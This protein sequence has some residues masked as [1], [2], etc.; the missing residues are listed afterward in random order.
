VAVTE[1]EIIAKMLQAAPEMIS[2]LL[3]IDSSPHQVEDAVKAIVDRILK[4]L[5]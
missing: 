4:Q 3:A 1:H 2:V 5:G